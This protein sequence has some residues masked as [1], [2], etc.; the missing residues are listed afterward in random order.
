MRDSSSGRG[1]SGGFRVYYHFDDSEILLLYIIRRN[2]LREFS[3][4]R[5][6]EILRNEGKFDD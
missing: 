5:I 3:L 1:K 4:A 2:R 6:E